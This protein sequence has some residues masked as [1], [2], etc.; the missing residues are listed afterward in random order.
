MRKKLHFRYWL[1]FIILIILLGVLV[2]WNINSGSIPISLQDVFRIIS[3]S[4]GGAFSEGIIRYLKEQGWNVDFSIHLNTWL[5]SELM[6]S[7]GTFLI[8]ATITNDWVQGLSLPIDGSR[9]IPNANY[10]IRKKSN[11]GYQYR[12]RDWI[13]SGSFWNANNG[14]TWNQL[15]PILDSWLIQNP[16][17]QINYG[18]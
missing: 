2:F 8:D 9:D 15:M 1:S 10:K 18:Q 16:N 3:H 6:G 14:I 13:D 11:E 4:M 5:P 12:H 7:V 17:I